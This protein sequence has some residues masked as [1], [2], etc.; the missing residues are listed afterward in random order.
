MELAGHVA[1]MGGRRGACGVLIGRPEG[2]TSLGR[3]RLSW[4]D[5]ITMNIQEVGW[6][7]MGWFAVSRIGTDGRL[8]RMR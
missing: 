5:N 6:G 7:G 1:R 4:E 3:P 8:L 2:K